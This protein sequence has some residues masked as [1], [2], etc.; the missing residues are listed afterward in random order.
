MAVVAENARE[1]RPRECCPSVITD[2]ATA[3]PFFGKN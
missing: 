2:D 3:H 1:G